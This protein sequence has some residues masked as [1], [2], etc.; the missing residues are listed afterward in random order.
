MCFSSHRDLNE[1]RFRDAE[2]K[3]QQQRV[4]YR[5]RQHVVQDLEKYH[6]ALSHAISKFH[7][8]KM[9]QINKA[10][11]DLWKSTYRGNDIDYIEI[12]ADD[13][14]PNASMQKRKQ[15][16]YRVSVGERSRNKTV[17]SNRCLFFKR[18]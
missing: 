4:Q 10:I 1:P 16:N 6:K 11:R 13:V 9:S 14:D 15:I 18:W 8:H 2:K 7:H 5:V 3:Y 12:K 17:V